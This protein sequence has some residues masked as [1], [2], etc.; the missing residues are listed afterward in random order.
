LT[1]PGQHAAGQASG[2]CDERSGDADSLLS[3]NL[4]GKLAQPGLRELGSLV[5]GNVAVAVSNL[6][7]GYGD[8]EILHDFSLLL[9]AGQSLCL[10]GPNGAGKSTVLHSIYGFTRLISGTVFVDGHDVTRVPPNEKL[11]TSGIAY[12]LQDNSVFPEMTVEENLLMGGFLMAHPRDAQEAAE[13]V[14][15]KYPRLAQRRSHCAAVLSGGERRLL[16]IARG[17]M[18][19]PSVLLVDEPSIGLEPRFIE[20]VFEILKELQQDAG[21][22]IILVEQNAKKGLE[23]ADI[24]YVLV[25]GRVAMAGTGSD[26]LRNPDVGR[27]FLGS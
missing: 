10:V 19:N 17:M 24:G 8:M 23:F 20:M 15:E 26:L 21:K 27:L 12:V 25:S 4:T 1:I 16:E 2:R 6:A 14:F 7:A 11:K 9:G 22:T 5:L 3:S 13:K 18:M